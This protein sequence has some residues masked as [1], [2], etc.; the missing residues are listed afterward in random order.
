VVIG[1]SFSVLAMIGREPLFDMPL[2]RVMM[3]IS[4]QKIHVGLT[5]ARRFC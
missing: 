1:R 2:I 3:R 5:L 4:V